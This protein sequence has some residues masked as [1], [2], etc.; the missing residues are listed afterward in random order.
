MHFN[1]IQ[2]EEMLGIK[3]VALMPN[4]PPKSK[5]KFAKAGPVQETLNLGKG[6]GSVEADRQTTHNT[7]TSGLIH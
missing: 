5:A 4:Y 6:K 2:G 1:I 7:E 3:G